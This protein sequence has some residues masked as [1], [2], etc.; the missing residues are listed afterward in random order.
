MVMLEHVDLLLSEPQLDVELSHSSHKMAGMGRPAPGVRGDEGNRNFE[1]R[2]SHSSRSAT[3][4]A[5]SVVEMEAR[6]SESLLTTKCCVIDYERDKSNYTE[7]NKR[8]NN[9]KRPENP[10]P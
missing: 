6:V 1:V 10:R 8:E 7:E 2:G 4:G 3:S 5:A 9:C